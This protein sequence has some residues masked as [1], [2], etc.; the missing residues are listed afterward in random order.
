MNQMESGTLLLADIGGYTRYLTGV[1]LDHSQD[2]LADLISTIADQTKGHFR[3]AKLEG[4][5]I[6]C[7]SP[8]GKLDEVALINTIDGCYFAFKERLRDIAQA[9][10]CRCGACTRVPMLSLKFVVHFGDYI[11]HQVAGSS[12]LVGGDVILVHRLL[13]NDIVETTGTDAYAFITSKCVDQLGIGSDG[14]AKIDSVQHY[15]DVGDVKG[16]VIDMAA[17][18]EQ[19]QERREV[20]VAPGEEIF[21]TTYQL[22]VPVSLAWEVWTGPKRAEWMKGVTAFDQKN[23]S[24][25]RGVGTV[26]HC[27]HGKGAA[28]IEHVV[29]YKPFR[30]F[31]VDATVPKVGPVLITYEM[32]PVGDERTKVTIR[33]RPGECGRLRQAFIKMIGSQFAKRFAETEEEIKEYFASR[34]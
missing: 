9:T 18:W 31:T 19:E 10:S 22:D 6:F 30:Y 23:P 5:A 34:R 24:G 3:L 32:E 1:E 25:M 17:R 13:K 27:M 8:G 28:T 7:N 26:N 21:E 16:V 15:D 11:T 33:G 29:D 12:E 2:I 20:L 14:L 4:D